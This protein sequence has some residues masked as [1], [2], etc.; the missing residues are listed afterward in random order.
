MKLG[1]S[2]VLESDGLRLEVLVERLLSQI[3][4]EPRHLE[5]AERSGDVCLVISVDEAGAGIDAL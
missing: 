1:P 5:S 2:V 3:L 4:A